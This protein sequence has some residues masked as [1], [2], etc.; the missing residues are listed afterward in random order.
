MLSDCIYNMMMG[1]LGHQLT[2]KI[3]FRDEGNNLYGYYEMGAYTI[4][5]QDYI[6]GEIFKGEERICE[7]EANYMGF[8]DFDKVRYWDIRE[9]EKTWFKVVNDDPNSLP[10]DSKRRKDSIALLTLT[11]EE[12]QEE[13]EKIEA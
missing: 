8:F 2:G 10:S 12:A 5:K 11:S 4:R 9:K 3:E 6:Y 7:V 13:K 1:T